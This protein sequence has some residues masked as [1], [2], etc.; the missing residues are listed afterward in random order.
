MDVRLL[1]AIAA[2]TVFLLGL[3]LL[4][5]LIAWA[6]KH[7]QFVPILLLNFFLGGTFFGW[8]VAMIWSVAHIPL[9]ARD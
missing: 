3:Y 4:P 8:W 6:R 9:E 2:G 7:H 5:S 1:I